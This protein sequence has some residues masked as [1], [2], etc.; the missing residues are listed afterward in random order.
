MHHCIKIKR[1]V[2]QCCKNVFVSVIKRKI[3]DFHRRIKESALCGPFW[4]LSDQQFFSD[5]QVEKSRIGF[6]FLDSV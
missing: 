3:I 2:V 4:V 5:S 6:G 1:S